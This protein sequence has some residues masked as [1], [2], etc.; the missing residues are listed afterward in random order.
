MTVMTI[1]HNTWK[2]YGILYGP[3]SS[4]KVLKLWYKTIDKHTLWNPDTAQ[5][6]MGGYVAKR[7]YEFNKY[8]DVVLLKLRAGM[9]L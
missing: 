1:W 7:N 3:A 2:W 4:K 5:R 6:V 8:W 9:K